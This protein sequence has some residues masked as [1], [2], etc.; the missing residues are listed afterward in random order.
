RVATPADA[1]TTW[2]AVRFVVD[3][4]RSRRMLRERFPHALSEGAEGAFCRW[5]RGEGGDGP[6][7]SPTARE[8]IPAAFAAPPARVRQLYRLRE[9][10]RHAFPLALTPAGRRDFFQ[11]LTAHG[12]QEH[13]LR[14]EEMWWFLLECDED[15]PRELVHSYGLHAGWQ[16]RFPDGL[17]VFGREAFAD[18]R[19]EPHGLVASWLDPLRWPVSLTPLDVVRLGYSAHESWLRV[20]PGAVVGGDGTRALGAWIL[21]TWQ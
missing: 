11:W 13:G 3:L 4:L 7:L 20:V 14:A 12:G 2:G 10:L 19:R 8:R 5:L 9:D 18:W 21:R 6:G 16:R 1:E 17:T 15:P